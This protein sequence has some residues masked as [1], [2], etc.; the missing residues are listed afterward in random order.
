[1]E[2][3]G[4]IIKSPFI[5]LGWLIIGAVAGT[6]AHRFVTKSNQPLIVDI[7]VGWIGAFL[8]GIIFGL[9]NIETAE[10]GIGGFIANL[11]VATVGAVVLQFLLRTLRGR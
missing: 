8:G 11:V 6:L 3:I 4:D 9:F 1:M 10:Y 2:L 7:I 5:C